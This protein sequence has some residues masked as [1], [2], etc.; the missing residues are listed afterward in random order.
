MKAV[1]VTLR[2]L[3]V[4]RYVPQDDTIEYRLLLHDGK[5]KALVRQG[6]IT[7][8]AAMADV[9]LREA[10][11]RL[12]AVHGGASSDDDPL[13]G[14]VLIRLRGDE[15][16]LGERIAKFFA[17]VR[18]RIRAAK[19]ARMSYLEIERKVVGFSTELGA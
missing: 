9:L 3:D 13:A 14:A 10:R 2:R 11:Q 15:D 5:E 19:A 7:D 16:V 1:D 18:E 8:P 6:R 12:T 4:V 17:T